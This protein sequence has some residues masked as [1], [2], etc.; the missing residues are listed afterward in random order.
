M[1]FNLTT[2][3]EREQRTRMSEVDIRKNWY[4]L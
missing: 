4:V 1:Q 2:D 3:R